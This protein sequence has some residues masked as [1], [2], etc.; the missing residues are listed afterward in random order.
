MLPQKSI[1]S[2]DRFN[3]RKA[4]NEHDARLSLQTGSHSTA[5]SNEVLRKINSEKSLIT[6]L[7]GEAIDSSWVGYANGMGLAYHEA[8]INKSKP[9]LT[10]DHLKKALNQLDLQDQL[11]ALYF[12]TGYARDVIHREVMWGATHQITVEDYVMDYLNASFSIAR[13]DMKPG[14]KT[15]VSI[16]YAQVY[17]SKKNR[18]LK[19]VLPGH[20]DLGVES[21]GFKTKINWKR[22]KSNYFVHTRI[23]ENIDESRL[24]TE[25][26]SK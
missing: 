25:L 6:K 13:K 9:I 23:T 1:W 17:N 18:L 24:E 26:V 21:R 2:I 15:C 14:H 5:E 16:L 8:A 20:V 7:M 12:L 11:S 10:V 22:P 19:S 3:P 4:N